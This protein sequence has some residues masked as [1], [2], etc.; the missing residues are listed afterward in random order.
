MKIIFYTLQT[1]FIALY[2][3]YKIIF[4]EKFIA[5]FFEIKR[6]LSHIIIH[7]V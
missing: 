2:G 5:P 3:F 1:V 7:V 4:S 6:L